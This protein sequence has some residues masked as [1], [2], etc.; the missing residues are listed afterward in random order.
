MSN[1]LYLDLAECHRIFRKT[2]DLLARALAKIF[3]EVR[4]AFS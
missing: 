2:D 1:G 3:G 4:K